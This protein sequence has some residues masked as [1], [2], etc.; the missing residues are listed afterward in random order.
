MKKILCLCALGLAAALPPTG[1]ALA[2]DHRDGDFVL[3]DPSTDINDVYT[4]MSAD[5]SKVYLAMTVFPAANAGATLRAKI[6]N[7]LFQGIMCAVTPNGSRMVKS[8]WSGPRGICS[9]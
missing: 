7:G 8:T 2:A 6:F 4:W 1:P 3:A 9:P 5:A